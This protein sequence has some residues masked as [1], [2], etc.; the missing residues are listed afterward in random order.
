[1]N[2][3]YY[4]CTLI[5]EYTKEVYECKSISKTRAKKSVLR[6]LTRNVFYERK[7]DN[8]YPV[9]YVLRFDNDIVIAKPYME[10]GK[11]IYRYG[12]T[13]VHE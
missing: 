7:Y 1:M 3:K 6:A 10:N 11:I 12:S 8:I 4:T 9:K 5:N 13:L 2:Y